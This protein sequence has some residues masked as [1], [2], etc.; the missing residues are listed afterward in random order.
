MSTPTPT[1]TSAPT[2]TPTRVVRL[3]GCN[4]QVLE[5]AHVYE[6]RGGF[7]LQ[8]VLTTRTQRGPVLQAGEYTILYQTGAYRK[9]G[10]WYGAASDISFKHTPTANNVPQIINFPAVAGAADQRLAEQQSCGNSVSFTVL[11][12]GYLDMTFTAGPSA[13]IFNLNGSTPTRE[14]NGSGANPVFRIFKTKSVIPTPTPT[15]TNT[16]TPTKTGVIPTPTPTKTNRPTPT[17]T[18]TNRPTPTPTRTNTPTPTKT[19]VITTATP[20]RTNTPT[21]TKTRV[22]PTPTPTKTSTPTP[23]KTSAS[24]STPTPTRTNTPTPTKTSAPTLTPTPT[25]TSTPTPTPTKTIIPLPVFE[26][27]CV[28]LS[29]TRQQQLAQANLI[30]SVIFNPS[31]G[32]TFFYSATGSNL[33]NG[34]FGVIEPAYINVDDTKAFIKR[35]NNKWELYWCTRLINGAYNRLS[36]NE[37]SSNDINSPFW[38]IVTNPSET[39]RLVDIGVC[40][41]PPSPTMTPTPTNT[42]T[43]SIQSVTPTTTPTKTGTP[44]PT[45]TLT[46]TSTPTPSITPTR[47]TQGEPDIPW[48]PTPQGYID[49]NTIKR[50]RLEGFPDEDTF[51]TNVVPGSAYRVSVTGDTALLQISVRDYISGSFIVGYQDATAT[52][53]A[54]TPQIAFTVKSFFGWLGGGFQGYNLLVTPLTGG[55]PPTTP[56]PTP[57]VTRTQ[58]P[59]PTRTSS[60]TWDSDAA[61]YIQRVEQQDGQSLET[62]V[63]TAIDT[64][65]KGLKTDSTWGSIDVVCLLAGARTLSGALVA[66]KGPDPTNYNFTQADYHRSVGLKG[67]GVNKW[68]DSNRLDS[69]RPFDNIHMSAYMT[70]AGEPHEDERINNNIHYII[71]TD[72]GSYFMSGSTGMYTQVEMSD[73]Y[74]GIGGHGIGM[75]TVP[76]VTR[77]G[78]W[79]L[80]ISSTRVEVV[81]R[82]LNDNYDPRNFQIDPAIA[83]PSYKNLTLFYN[84]MSQEPYCNFSSHRM[85]CYTFGQNIDLYKLQNRFD[86]FFNTLSSIVSPPPLPTPTPSPTRPPTWSGNAI[87]SVNYIPVTVQKNSNSNFDFVNLGDQPYTY[88]TNNPPLTCFRG[89]NYNFNV[90]SGVSTFALRNSYTDTSNVIGTYN[91][92]P[93]SGQVS[94]NTIM[95][96]PL[97]STPNQ[98]VYMSPNTPQLSGTI[99]ILD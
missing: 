29:E 22:I 57:T 94:N 53:Q 56:T 32:T 40:S 72:V 93:V 70:R 5:P 85:S 54:T 6:L 62:N 78:F 30:P 23:T 95:F 61:S 63:K 35:R 68:L 12:S 77:P 92:S 49:V 11:S 48:Y 8:T 15:K 55:L 42:P 2:P 71:G 19:R 89:A 20:T 26:N 66:L 24:T 16:P 51:W 60:F 14:T 52:F 76:V 34:Q 46:R 86:T 74:T 99:T 75:G 47:P 39:F 28:T 7:A 1:R 59:T 90:N 4:N 87:Y 84:G 27:I 25:K 45:P 65:V 31:Q 79:G 10:V 73:I 3:A 96:T 82:E 37:H 21:P 18:K 97:S 33:T 69:A 67:N 50:S 13:Q 64:L 83:V 17:P 9:Q 98:I 44:T 80:T 91:N 88:G 81:C 41:T 58:T 43:S 36:V 38:Y